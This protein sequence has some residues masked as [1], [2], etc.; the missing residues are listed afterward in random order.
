MNYEGSIWISGAKVLKM[1]IIL[2][3][4]LKSHIL[5]EFEFHLQTIL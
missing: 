2:D 5:L 4:V 3:I 1:L